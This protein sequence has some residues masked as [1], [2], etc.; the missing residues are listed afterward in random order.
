MNEYEY[1]HKYNFSLYLWEMNKYFLFDFNEHIC[2]Y[3][4]KYFWFRIH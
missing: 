1:E 4:Y 3:Y 2:E